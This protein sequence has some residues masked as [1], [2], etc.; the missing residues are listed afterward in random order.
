M[1]S[2]TT[3]ESTAE[4]PTTTVTTRSTSAATTSDGFCVDAVKGN[5]TCA[6]W[7]PLQQHASWSDVCRRIDAGAVV[8]SA[9]AQLCIGSVTNTC[10]DALLKLQCALYCQ[11]CF[12]ANT[13]RLDKICS[14]LCEDVRSQCGQ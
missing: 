14:P 6:A 11:P 12:D 10:Y 4:T 8:L 2:T 9:E 3:T 1:Q 13:I 7:A 5:G